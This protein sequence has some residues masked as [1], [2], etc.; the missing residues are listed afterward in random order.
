MIKKEKNQN[1]LLTFYRSGIFFLILSTIYHSLN[2]A[3]I[4]FLYSFMFV[5]NIES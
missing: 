3:M 1:T 5:A 2:D 4:I